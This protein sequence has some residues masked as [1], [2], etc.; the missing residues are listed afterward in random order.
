MACGP[1]GQ[2]AADITSVIA[3]Y[4]ALLIAKAMRAASVCRPTDASTALTA[5]ATI[6]DRAVLS[7]PRSASVQL[8]IAGWRHC[9]IDVSRPIVNL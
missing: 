4:S 8:V 7:R 9:R 6:A 1:F 5:S 3:P 2:T